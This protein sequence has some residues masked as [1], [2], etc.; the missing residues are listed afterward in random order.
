MADDKARRR[1]LTAQYKQTHPEAGVYRIVN[2]QT[3][4]AFLGSAPNLASVRN[5]L[6][7]GRSTNSLGVL[8]HR[9]RADAQQYGL[10]AFELEV[11]ESL[12]PEPEMT[13]TQIREE[14]TTL[15]ALW[16]EKYDPATLY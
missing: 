6:E 9:M 4:R 8:D 12:Q 11:L 1:D 5:K 14:L 3:G 16:R 10:A 13:A 2:T 7:F 15:E